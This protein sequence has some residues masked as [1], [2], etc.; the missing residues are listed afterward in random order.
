MKLMQLMKDQREV[1][2]VKNY[3]TEVTKRLHDKRWRDMVEIFAEYGK[4]TGDPARDARAVEA[5]ITIHDPR[6]RTLMEAPAKKAPAKKKPAKKK[7]PGG[8]RAAP[9]K[10][11][12]SVDVPG[13]DMFSGRH[14]PLSHVRGGKGGEEPE[15]PGADE[16][17]GRHD[18]L[19]HIRKSL[20]DLPE[21]DDDEDC[22]L[23]FTMNAKLK[24]LKIW[25][26]SLVAGYSCP[27]A[28]ACRMLVKKERDRFPSEKGGEMWY[29]PNQDM[30][31]LDIE[32]LEK[33]V[34]AHP[35][36]AIPFKCFS[37][38]AEHQYVDTQ[39]L[40]WRNFDLLLKVKDDTAKMAD[41]IQR[42]L[43]WHIRKHGE[44]RMFRMTVDGDFFSQKY[45]DAWVEVCTNNPHILF[46]SFTTSIQFWVNRL[47]DIPKN[48]RISGSIGS[49]QEDLIHQHGLRNAQVVYDLDHA[50]TLGR[51]IDFDDYL[52][53]LGDENFALL[54]H[55]RARPG[56]QAH[57]MK[58]SKVIKGVANQI[59]H[60]DIE[61]QIAKY[62]TGRG[63]NMAAQK[64]KKG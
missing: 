5:M 2:T 9:K 22:L 13:P 54:V 52:A 34:R 62:T 12:T 40:H 25:G 60:A 49:K 63:E 35:E 10:K 20:Q 36:L 47:D 19:S 14:D 38:G 15:I 48:M 39:N 43:D 27:F 8:T 24:H 45:F 7:A 21:I 3:I 53:A 30:G 56:Y 16:F 1:A 42:S 57:T 31:R 17:A 32:E 11:T 61:K 26:L 29:T 50:S 23:R 46:Y 59:S 4:L 37:G 6:Y 18:P 64:P 44:I 28:G 51:N 55:G 41:L 33:Q 58:N